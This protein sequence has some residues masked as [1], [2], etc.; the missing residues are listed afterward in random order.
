MKQANDKFTRDA[1]DTPRPGRPPDPNAKT[2]A[3]RARE[4]R[5]RQKQK[6]FDFLRGAE[7]DV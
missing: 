1:F 2:P 7:N 6:K 4:Y 5:A 3:Q